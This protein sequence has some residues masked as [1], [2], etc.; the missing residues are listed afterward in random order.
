MGVRKCAC[1]ATMKKEIV[2]GDI[3]WIC[4]LC[5]YKEKRKVGR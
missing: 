5:G 1:G 2:F 3:V 4:T